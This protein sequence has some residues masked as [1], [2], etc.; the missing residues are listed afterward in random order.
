MRKIILLLFLTLATIH[1]QA[2]ELD[3]IVSVSSPTLE[4]TDKK[5][6]E[7]LQTAIYD[8]MNN[9]TWTNFH[10]KVE[11][12]IECTILLTINE[13]PTSDD[14]NGTLNIVLRRPVLNT[15]YN[16][17]LLN[18]IDRD[19]TFKYIEYQSLDYS[20]NTFSSNLT[21]TLAFY[22]YMFLGYYFDSFALYGGTPFFEKAQEVVNAAQSS[23]E[24][25]WKAFESD[26]NR[27]WMVA[28]ILNP[29]YSSLREFSYL[30]HRQGLD[31]MYERV[32]LG[33]GKITESLS[34]LQ[35]ISTARPGFFSLQLILDAKKDEFVNIYSDLR[36]PP[37]EK[38]NVVNLLKEIDPAN[39]SKYQ[40]ILG[41]K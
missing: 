14:F 26:K 28:N 22:T 10:I 38:N 1:L 24:S 37:L 29:A 23:R 16:T 31:Q 6:F 12:R 15:A 8:F 40:E 11:E 30:Y 35:K 21:S 39:S 17:I 25:G 3:C 9:R 5:I 4:G 20:D 34:L 33:R 18:Y 7:T 27:Y 13:R 2:Q 19:F 41:G 32:D 36:V